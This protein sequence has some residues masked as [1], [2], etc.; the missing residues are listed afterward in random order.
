MK[1]VGRYDKKDLF[2]WISRRWNYAN[3][4]Q[5]IQSLKTNIRERIYMIPCKMGMDLVKVDEKSFGVREQL[6]I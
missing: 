5:K 3:A 6:I 1:D 2:S 4:D